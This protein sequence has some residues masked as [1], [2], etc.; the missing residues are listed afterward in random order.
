MKG[1]ILVQ[2]TIGVVLFVNLFYLW[3]MV[4][5]LQ[6]MS[7]LLLFNITLPANLQMFLIS[8]F[9]V[10]NFELLSVDGLSDSIFTFSVIEK[11]ALRFDQANIQARHY[12]FICYVG[13][14]VY[15]ILVCVALI[16]SLKFFLIF[17]R[18]LNKNKVKGWLM[19][20]ITSY[21]SKIKW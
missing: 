5:V 20:Q 6:V 15:V 1:Q 7:H 3:S 9:D 17:Y 19:Y 2:L 10:A 8:M 11:L 21:S 4:N 18:A 14:D 16:A 12:S 13:L